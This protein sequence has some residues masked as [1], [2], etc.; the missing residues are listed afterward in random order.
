[1][2]HHAR[3][4]DPYA[5]PAMDETAASSSSSSSGSQTPASAFWPR[6]CDGGRHVAWLDETARE[7]QV[8]AFED[9]HT[10][11]GKAAPQALVRCEQDIAAWGIDIDAGL[12]VVVHAVRLED[13]EDDDIG[14]DDF[15]H[16]PQHNAEAPPGQKLTLRVYDLTTGHRLST[17]H[18]ACLDCDPRLNG[19]LRVEVLGR[20]VLLQTAG[21]VQV[22][23]WLRLPEEEERERPPQNFWPFAWVRPTGVTDDPLLSAHLLGCD[24][25]AVLSR[26]ANSSH[27]RDWG[28]TIELYK[29]PLEG[30][31]MDF[32][33]QGIVATIQLPIRA[34]PAPKEVSWIRTGLGKRWTDKKQDA[35]VAVCVEGF[36]W[37]ADLKSFA[38]ST[39]EKS[40]HAAAN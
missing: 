38:V 36:V 34:R 9:F 18:Q 14:S 20:H 5:T 33:A 27:G 23:R 19:S 12:V 24:V 21:Y 1:M 25:V 3:V 31:E 35:A 17:P 22:L 29:L 13:D 28:S 11:N 2:R 7:I 4:V 8:W 26:P 40:S 6:L 39:R 30:Q 32:H 15:D 10:D 16:G 37:M